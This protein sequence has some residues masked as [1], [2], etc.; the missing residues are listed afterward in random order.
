M[1]GPV[2]L[3]P[4]ATRLNALARSGEEAPVAPRSMAAESA[5]FGSRNRRDT[6]T[7]TG[8]GGGRRGSARRASPG[9]LPRALSSWILVARER[10]GARVGGLWRDREREREGNG[11]ER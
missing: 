8:A 4:A 9:R 6:A 5:R 1:P 3:S 2:R 7:G 10:D 11:E